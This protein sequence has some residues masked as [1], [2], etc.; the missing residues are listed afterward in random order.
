MIKTKNEAQR[1]MLITIHNA[2]VDDPFFRG[3]SRAHHE[4][5]EILAAVLAAQ[6]DRS[7]SNDEGTQPSE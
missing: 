6:S 7:S 4:T 1:D 3:K 5:V 2:I